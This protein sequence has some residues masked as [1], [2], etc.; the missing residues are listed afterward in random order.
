MIYIFVAE[1]LTVAEAACHPFLAPL[2]GVAYF[3][4]RGSFRG[5]PQVFLDQKDFAG[6]P[7]VAPEIE[8]M[9]LDPI[10][11]LKRGTHTTTP[12]ATRQIAQVTPMQHSNTS[13]SSQSSRGYNSSR[14]TGQE[15]AFAFEQNNNQVLVNQ[16]QPQPRPAHSNAAVTGINRDVEPIDLTQS[17]PQP[18]HTNR[19]SVGISPNAYLHTVDRAQSSDQGISNSRRPPTNRKRPRNQTAS[20]RQVGRTSSQ[21]KGQ[22][23]PVIHSSQGIDTSVPQQMNKPVTDMFKSWEN[24]MSKYIDKSQDQPKWSERAGQ[25]VSTAIEKGLGVVSYTSSGRRGGQESNKFHGA[26]NS[27]EL[28][29]FALQPNRVA[30]VKTSKNAKPVD[31]KLRQGST[32]GTNSVARQRKKR[33]TPI[34]KSES[35]HSNTISKKNPPKRTFSSGSDEIKWAQ[36]ARETYQPQYSD[37]SNSQSIDENVS[38]R[39]ISDGKIETNFTSYLQAHHDRDFK[40]SVSD[41]NANSLHFSNQVYLSGTGYDSTSEESDTSESGEDSSFV[42]PK[43]RKRYRKTSSDSLDMTSVD[44]SNSSSRSGLSVIVNGFAE[45]DARDSKKTELREVLLSEK[46]AIEKN[47]SKISQ[48]KGANEDGVDLRSAQV[49]RFHNPRQG[50]ID[51]SVYDFESEMYQSPNINRKVPTLKRKMNQNGV[52]KFFANKTPTKSKSRVPNHPGSG[53]SQRKRPTVRIKT[54]AAH[55]AS[56]QRSTEAELPRR[57]SPRKHAS[58]ARLSGS[59]EGQLY[60]NGL[61][62]VIIN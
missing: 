6:Q 12:P 8:R 59:V 28:R 57:T 50:R 34:P 49:D 55:R 24:S 4:P 13:K 5:Y 9:S 1:R 38:P 14:N 2:A 32:D 45:R 53:G 36:L 44:K 33:S 30:K 41:I 11:L 29:S 31:S 52:A 58:T 22:N 7:T 60:Q 10:S 17:S 3:L 23:G 39:G 16:H 18:I 46:A 20:G 48:K 19:P 27:S 51:A 15:R 61:N 56:S 25:V 26:S 43:K 62:E 40:R 42:P 54:I 47:M 21:K 35:A 37:I